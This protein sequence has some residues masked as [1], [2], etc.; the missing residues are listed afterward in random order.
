MFSDLAE[1]QRLSSTGIGQFKLPLASLQAIDVL[2]HIF[3]QLD[4]DELFELPHNTSIVVNLGAETH[5]LVV[6]HSQSTRSMRWLWAADSHTLD[7]FDRIVTPEIQTHLLYTA[8]GIVETNAACYVV[9]KDGV[10]DKECV[11]HYDFYSSGIPRAAAFSLMT[12]MS[13]AHP[14]CVGG[15]EFWPWAGADK[16]H[17]DSETAF[18][19]DTRELSLA[20]KAYSHG[21]AT[22]IDGRLLHRTQPFECGESHGKRPAPLTAAIAGGE[23]RV[24]LCVNASRTTADSWPHLQRLLHR[25]VGLGLVRSETTKPETELEGASNPLEFS[26][27]PQKGGFLLRKLMK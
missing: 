25:Q 11:P 14:Q 24:L 27:K 20:V 7:V 18:R 17:K 9:V 6:T 2:H 16:A 26:A 12:P 10:T 13:A 19:R 1:A 21:C 4:I 22:I 5:T 3:Q 15:L 8:G 23:L